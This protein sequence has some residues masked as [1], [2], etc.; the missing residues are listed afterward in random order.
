MNSL[1]KPLNDPA[2]WR[3]ITDQVMGGV[4]DLTIQHADGVFLMSGNVSTDNN[5]G[6]VRLSNRIDINRK[7]ILPFEFIII[8]K[9]VPHVFFNVFP[10][11]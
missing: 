1:S 9:E 8:F 7:P 3:G 11:T 5:G 2:D 10:N 4:S 6:F